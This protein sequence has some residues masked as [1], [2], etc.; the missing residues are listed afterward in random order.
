MVVTSVL[1]ALSTG[2]PVHGREISEAMVTLD[3]WFEAF[4]I[5]RPWDAL[6]DMS[7]E[8]RRL[9]GALAYVHHRLR[10]GEIPEKP[11]AHLYSD[12]ERLLALDDAEQV[13]ESTPAFSDYRAF[14][15]IDVFLLW[16]HLITGAAVPIRWNAT[17]REAYYSQAD[18]A[19][20]LFGVRM[21]PTIEGRATYPL[22]VVLGGGPRVDPS[23]EFPFIQVNP[24]RG[25]IW[26]Y[27]SISGYDVMQVIAFM[28]RHYPVDPDRI[29]LAGF[30]AGAS[31][32]MHVAS[33]YPDQFAAVLPLV[34]VGSDY[35]IAN[36]R[37]LPVAIH[38][39]TEDWTSSI[40]NARVQYD[41]MR[42]LGCPVILEEYP[43]IGHSVPQPHGRLVDWLLEHTR[44]RSPASITHQ[45]ETPTLGRS[46][47]IQIHEFQDPH[48]RATLEAAVDLSDD[49][50]TVRI[51][52]TNVQAF[53]LDLD[54]V[55]GRV[56]TVEIDGDRTT[57]KSAA[58]RLEYRLH[59]GHWQVEPDGDCSEP[60]KRP[61]HAGAAANLYQGE[62]LRIVYGTGSRHT[63]RADQLRSAAQK[64][65]ACGGPVFYAM[66][67][68][69]PV[70]ADTALS[71]EQEANG[72]LILLGAPEEN[73]V[74]RSILH[75]LPVTIRNDTLIVADRPP[76]P[77]RDQ[78]LSLLYPHPKHPKRLVYL[79]APFTDDDG[80]TRFCETPQR[81]LVG[82]DG[83][84][85]VSQ[86]DLVVQNLDNRIGRQM[87]FGKDWDWIALAGSD[88]PIPPRFADRAHLALAYMKVMRRT[89]GADFA[90][91]WGPAD[92][93]MWGFDF[94]YL[95]RYN[96]DLYTLA[97]FR[98]QHH[99]A[100]TM[101]GSVSGGELK[102]IRRRW[103]D[104]LLIVPDV[105]TEAVEDQEHYRVHIPTDL[106]IKLGQREKALADPKPGL[107]ISSE[108]VMAEIFQ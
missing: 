31:G 43:A 86:A 83:F 94:N 107:A 35:P 57:V 39:G 92:K 46:Y 12:L 91:W 52:P 62:P 108:D 27:R 4:A 93:G 3:K 90:F 17:F 53:A 28:K 96:P 40:C 32:A 97:D 49:R 100:E 63:G 76:L 48:Q 69:F 47:W 6:P 78:V 26:G 42:Q 88:T 11:L 75:E 34:A 33:C 87:Q 84:D 38:H 70:V 56:E 29:Y 104:E 106:Y 18:G 81:F 99:L 5:E 16:K 80:L 59:E 45:C 14:F 89:S 98:T 25:R 58:K 30:S 10:S 71:P 67:N 60:S 7:D 102:E 68:H 54:L 24:S 22:L 65:A 77:L 82:S 23:H 8:G 51:H 37:N 20:M 95:K 41:R 101:T 74:T 64:L 9:R 1:L 19:G 13:L 2:S 61:Y 85:R 44:N 72:N 79:M 66:Q 15:E 21:P 55:P 105:P 73:R 50:G 103:G 36:F